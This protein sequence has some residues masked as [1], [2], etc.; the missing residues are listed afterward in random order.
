M[1]LRDEALPTW[2]LRM[3]DLQA[4]A[5]MLKTKVRNRISGKLTKQP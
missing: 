1:K 3:R 2:E 5:A 4:Q